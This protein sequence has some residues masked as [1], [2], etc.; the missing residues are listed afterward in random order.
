MPRP[1]LRTP[2]ARRPRTGM[3][4]AESGGEN[5]A[6]SQPALLVKAQILF[7]KERLSPRALSVVR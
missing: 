2:A 5:P 7:L 1:R 6:A 4:L 3:L